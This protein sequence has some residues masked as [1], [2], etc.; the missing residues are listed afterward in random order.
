[1]PSRLTIF[2]RAFFLILRDFKF[3]GLVVVYTRLTLGYQM[4][5]LIIRLPNCWEAV[6]VFYNILQ[7]CFFFF[8]YKHFNDI[9]IQ[10]L[11]CNY[12]QN[13]LYNIRIL[14]TFTNIKSLEIMKNGSCF[15]S[16]ASSFIESCL[17]GNS[18]FAYSQR[19]F[20]VYGVIVN[21]N[22]LTLVVG[23]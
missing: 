19:P 23:W 22:H 11:E 6:I 3:T 13:T 1:M 8:K 10:D 17:T 9:L 4:R 15:S 2:V 20:D 7:T 12:L 14:R 18:K 16:W 5:D 21:K